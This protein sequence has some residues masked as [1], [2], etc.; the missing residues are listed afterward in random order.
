[1][2]TPTAFPWDLSATVPA[3][4]PANDPLVSSIEVPSDGVIRDA[5]V[6]FPA[7]QAVGVKVA[8]ATGE[9][10]IP[11]GGSEHLTL[12]GATVTFEPDVPVEEGTVVEVELTNS[13][14]SN[15]HYCGVVVVVEE[16]DR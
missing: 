16:A 4:T 5:V 2:S 1:M 14:A 15:P 6:D 9:R 8:D 3:A 13:D 7:G 11:R 10:W 12:D